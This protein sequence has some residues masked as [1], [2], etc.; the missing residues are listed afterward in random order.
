MECLYTLPGVCVLCCCYGSNIGGRCTVG[1]D[2]LRGLFQPQWFCGSVIQWQ[3]CANTLLGTSVW[4]H[5]NFYSWCREQAET[6]IW[7]QD[8]QLTSFQ[9]SWAPFCSVTYTLLWPLQS[10]FYRRAA[11]VKDGEHGADISHE[12][13]WDN[14]NEIIFI[15]CVLR[16]LEIDL[17]FFPE[18]EYVY[19]RVRN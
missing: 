9:G 13:A 6:P 11:R 1:L 10:F 12:C 4:A 15:S 7:P 3:C 5:S 8:R 16:C 17:P 18:L 14:S 2:D 19:D